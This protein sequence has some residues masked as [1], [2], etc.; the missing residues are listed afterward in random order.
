MTRAEAATRTGSDGE[1]TWRRLRAWAPLLA[2]V[3]A[4]LGIAAIIGPDPVH[5]PPL[6]PAST[7][8]DGAKAVVDTLAALGADVSVR[9]GAPDASRATALLLDDTLSNDD[10]TAMSRW[11]EAGGTLVVADPYSPLNPADVARLRAPGPLTP[12]LERSC[13]VSALREVRRVD[14]GVVTL[15]QAPPGSTACFVGGR[16]R[17][18]PERGA[19]SAS[20]TEAWL[21][22]TTRGRGTVVALGGPGAFTNARLGKEDNAVLAAALLA[23]RP[24]E[25]VVVV[26]P[27]PPG[28][29]TKTLTD[30]VAPRVR[31]ALA[32][33]AL[34]FVVVVAW[35]ARRL[36]RPVVEAQ[37]VELA[38]SELV[39]AVGH[40]MQRARGS[41]RAAEILRHDLRRTLAV[42]LGLPADAAPDQV[43]DAAA[44]WSGIKAERVRD[45]L[46]GRTP[47]DEAALV[48]LARS[49]VSVREEVIGGR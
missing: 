43:A 8:P 25:R 10:R 13:S 18:P 32:Q 28:S 41:A 9:P 44:A 36:G 48:R 20:G 29:G 33:L 11:V 42:R 35:R 7:A 22:I 17:Q 24:G 30:L 45:V 1:H 6:D 4:A 2:L 3:V 21:V 12:G 40:L 19:G 34:A 47:S 38:G 23:P 5:G 39:V 31:L 16:S 27:R 14:T 37:P 46:E 26:G 15:L 49:V